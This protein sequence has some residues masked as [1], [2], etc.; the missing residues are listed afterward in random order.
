MLSNGSTS[1]AACD[2][3]VA[4][5]TTSPF[6]PIARVNTS[7]LLTAS[8]SGEPLVVCRIANGTEGSKRLRIVPSYAG[9]WS[10]RYT[11]TS[12]THTGAF[13][14]TRFCD[15]YRGRLP[16]SLNLNQTQDVVSGAALLGQVQFAP[17]QM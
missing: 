10:G 9:F 3:R 7:G 16:V 13:A 14:V 5:L 2:W 12:C 17:P 15:G 11:V 1:P 6:P 8:S 4:E